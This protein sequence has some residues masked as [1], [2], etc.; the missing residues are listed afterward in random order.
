MCV[1]GAAGVCVK[2]SV[3][4]DEHRIEGKLKQRHRQRGKYTV[5]GGKRKLPLV[6]FEGATV[7]V[8]NN[9]LIEL[10]FPTDTPDKLSGHSQCAC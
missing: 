10:Y 6:H 3:Q 9:Y 1:W 2:R 7:A 4:E 5:E 8:E